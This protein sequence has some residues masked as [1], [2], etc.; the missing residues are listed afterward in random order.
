MISNPYS[1][2]FIYYLEG[3]IP[4]STKL[5]FTHFL[6]NWEEE[7][8]TFLFF[9]VAAQDQVDAL[10][11]VQPHLVLLDQFQMTYEEWQGGMN[12]PAQIGRFFITLPWSSSAEAA[13]EGSIPLVLDPGVVFGNGAH[14]TTQDCLTALEQIIQSHQIKTAVDVG[15]GTGLLALAAVKLGCERCLALD[16]NYLAARTALTNIRY[17]GL[18]K[19]ILAFQ[20]RGES[21]M[22]IDADLLIANIHFD[23]MQRLV[24]LRGF[25]KKRFFILSGLM[26]SEAL[27]ISHLLARAPVRILE[28]WQRDGTWF[29]IL[30][31]STLLE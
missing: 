23:V 15:T 12:Q 4:S 28:D 16:F 6:G 19:Q 27:H 9:S 13:D 30:G 1:Q 20:G 21:Y 11:S 31:E 7:G 10:L 14:P 5:S 2:L 8:Y 18:E 26:R 29:T 22:D 17:N 24:Q 3:R 25:L